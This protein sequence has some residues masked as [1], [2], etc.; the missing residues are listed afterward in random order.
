MAI[1][2]SSGGAA[3]Y[4]YASERAPTDRAVEVLR[5]LRRFHGADVDMRKQLGVEM[6]M[7]ETDL[8]ALRHL[9][10][11]ESKGAAIAPKDLTHKLGISSAATAKLLARMSA[12]GHIRR[13]AN[14]Q[15]LRAQLIYTTPTARTEVRRALE[16]IHHKMLAAAADLSVD[17]QGTVIHFLDQLSAAVGASD[18]LPD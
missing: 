12:S 16:S 2:E 6:D 8:S 15:D 5:A 4:W 18:E 9:I 1:Q 7:N 11:A 3:S 10:A 17:Q 14:P 13:E